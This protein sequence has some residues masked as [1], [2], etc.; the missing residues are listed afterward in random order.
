MVCFAKDVKVGPRSQP[1]TKME[2]VLC[3]STSVQDP[4]GAGVPQDPKAVQ[5]GLGRGGGKQEAEL[6]GLGA[7]DQCASPSPASATA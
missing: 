1:G 5:E 3:T 4:S 2:L 6:P 7:S